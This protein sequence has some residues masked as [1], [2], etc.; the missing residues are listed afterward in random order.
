MRGQL[1]YETILA[2]TLLVPT[3]FN[4]PVMDFALLENHVIYIFQVTLGILNSK[5]PKPG[6]SYL[7]IFL[8]SF[9]EIIKT[10]SI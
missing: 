10:N 6:S 1:V 3:T 2:D 9:V 8:F 7:L 5:I 4:Y